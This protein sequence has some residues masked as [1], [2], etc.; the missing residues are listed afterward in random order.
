MERKKKRQE[1]LIQIA[2]MARLHTRAYTLWTI[3]PLPSC[4]TGYP[5]Q[6]DE[7]ISISLS[8][9][10]ATGRLKCLNLEA[11][12]RPA[13]SCSFF[14][15]LLVHSSFFA[16]TAGL[17]TADCPKGDAWLR[18]M[19]IR[20]LEI[21]KMDRSAEELNISDHRRRDMEW[22]E[23]GGQGEQFIFWE[24]LQRNVDAHLN[25]SFPLVLLLFS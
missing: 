12:S 4:S 10:E 24:S 9:R 23:R 22:E 14:P 11:R 18:I 1:R 8:S 5:F 25:L 16:R 13:C 19:K 3:Y 2:S 6:K 21:V 15:L 7:S 20:M 17:R